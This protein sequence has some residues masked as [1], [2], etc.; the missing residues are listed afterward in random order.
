MLVN[1]IGAF[2][3]PF[4]TLYLTQS[5]KFSPAEA[6]FVVS[7]W[8]AGSLMAGPVGGFLADRWGRRRTLLTSLI[9]GAFA[10]LAVGLARSTSEI[11]MA[12]FA[13]GFF[14]EMYRPP[15]VAAI[16]DVV[17]P[18]DRTRAFGFLYWAINLGFSIAPVVA[19]LMVA[20][21][22]L[23]L[24]FADAATTLVFAAI[25]FARV[26]ETRP[27]TPVPRDLFYGARWIAPYT[28]G[29]FLAFVLISF[30]GALV[31]AQHLVG[32]PLDMAAHGIDAKHYGL[33][34]CV[35]GLLIVLVQPA[36]TQRLDQFRKYRV[37]AV[38]ALLVGLGF[39]LTAIASTPAQYVGTIIVWSL[40]EIA[41]LPVA[42]TV[43]TDIAPPSL[44]GSYQGAYQLA[45]GAAF[46]IAPTLGG[47]VIAR[48]GAPTLWVGCFMAGVL[49]AIGHLAIGPANR[50][51][52]LERLAA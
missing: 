17:R 22:F 31:F 50:R 6:G 49:V 10:M 52:E 19:S 29:V 45:W 46:S 5:K 33:L 14:G 42:S 34:V 25:V 13:L 32:L 15:V 3:V 2:V 35:N 11:M 48:F 7:L 39:G 51:R 40:G 4:L 44:R 1:R 36:A 30:V 41:L 20:R 21:S 28:D 24:F 9:A 8:G 38:G 37:L 43:V 27:T 26:P 23:L 12:T 16:G 18:E 47:G